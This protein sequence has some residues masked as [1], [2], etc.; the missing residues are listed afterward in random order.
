MKKFSSSSQM[1]SENLKKY[2][3]RAGIIVV[4]TSLGVASVITVASDESMVSSKAKP[5]SVAE[6]EA[7]V[8]EDTKVEY[9]KIEYSD[10]QEAISES[11]QLAKAENSEEETEA[12]A[13]LLASNDEETEEAT[14]LATEAQATA[15]VSTTEKATTTTEAATEDTTT[16][17]GVALASSKK[18]TSKTTSSNEKQQLAIEATEEEEEEA[19]AVAIEVENDSYESGTYL[20]T[21]TA[22]AYCACSKC[23]GKSNGITASGTKATQGRTIAAPST[24]A[25][26]T[27]L[28]I[29]GHTYV[30]EDRGGSISGK[31]IDIYFENHSDAVNFGRQ[32]VEVYVK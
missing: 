19:K 15:E 9:S 7:S 30:V 10:L 1:L 24:F 28:V 23:C 26:G 2:L 18:T 16:E 27:E 32:K 5:V 3:K 17:S 31:R 29:D 20:G 6:A 12:V 25:F 22:T 8:I 11:E 13:L 14:T 4:T 21:Y